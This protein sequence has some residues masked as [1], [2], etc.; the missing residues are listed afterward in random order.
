MEVLCYDSRGHLL[1]IS[2]MPE[3]TERSLAESALMVF[4]ESEV[5]VI[6]GYDILFSVNE[7]CLVRVHFSTANFSRWAPFMMGL[8][9]GIDPEEIR[10]TLESLEMSEPFA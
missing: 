7:G 5:I 2:C 1:A 10:D 3:D 4:P 9:G 6:P 8:W